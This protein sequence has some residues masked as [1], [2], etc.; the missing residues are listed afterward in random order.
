MKKNQSTKPL[1]ATTGHRRPVTR[2]ELLA[3][4]IIP[5][6]GTLLAPQTIQMLLSSVANAQSSGS[7]PTAAAG[8]IPFI[9]LNLSGGAAMAGNFVPMNSRGSVISSYSKM[10]LGDNNVP[11]IREFG[12]G[13]FAG[14]DNGALI[15]KILD[16]IKSV[17]TTDALAKTTFVGVCVRSRDDSNE[18]P[19]NISGLVTK[20]GLIGSQLPN[21]GNRTTAT[22]DSNKAAYLLPPTPLAVSNFRDITNSLGY[23]ASLATQL[24]NKQKVHLTDLVSKLSSYQARKLASLQTGTQLQ[25]L[26]ECAGIKNTSLVEQG[27]SAVDPGKNSSFASLWQITSG[28]NTGSNDYVFGSMV[29]NTL[30]GNASGASLDMGGFDYHDNSRST[31]DNRDRAAGVTIGRILQ[32]ASL[33]SKPVFLYVT[34]DGAVSS[35]D[36]TSRTSPWTSDRGSA[37]AAYIFMYSPQGRPAVSGNQIGSFTDGQAADDQFVTGNDPARAAQAVFANYLQLNRLLARLPQIVGRDAFDAA[38]LSQ[39]VKVV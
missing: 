18:N 34:S 28:S 19:F 29:Y 20:A 2:R 38:T 33:L 5:F 27:T 3:H 22:G 11:I 16:G 36:S 37:G 25:K 39:V 8:L 30:L 4:G 10:G 23:S 32:S 13:T 31:G 17:L 7:C 35:A 26:I 1:W 14:M 9:N 12:G 24:N 21:L 6:A 15:S